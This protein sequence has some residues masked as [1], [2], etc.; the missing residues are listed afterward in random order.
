MEHSERASAGTDGARRLSTN[1]KDL[2]GDY[3]FDQLFNS[4]ETGLCFR[5]L[6][7]RMLVTADEQRVEGRKKSKDRITASA[8][9][10]ASDTI[11]LLLL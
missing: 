1:F 4:D 7:G 5:Q 3:T 11:Q 10:N 9:A 2:A 6:P 8:C